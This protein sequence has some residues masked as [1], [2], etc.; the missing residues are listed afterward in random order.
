MVRERTESE[1]V[2]SEHAWS[3]TKEIKMAANVAF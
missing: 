2:F 3:R 1:A